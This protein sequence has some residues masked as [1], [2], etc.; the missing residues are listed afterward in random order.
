MSHWQNLHYSRLCQNPRPQRPLSFH[1]PVAVPPKYLQGH[2]LWDGPGR[3]PSH[4]VNLCSQIY[5]LGLVPVTPLHPGSNRPAGV[6]QGCGDGIP[7]QYL[8]G[9]GSLGPTFCILNTDG[10]EYSST[11]C[12]ENIS[13]YNFKQLMIRYKKDKLHEVEQPAK[14]LVGEEDARSWKLL[15]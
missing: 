3:P 8:G 11:I 1:S 14:S 4:N 7:R 13:S 12:M 10:S 15:K 9:T 2:F 5:G 6:Y